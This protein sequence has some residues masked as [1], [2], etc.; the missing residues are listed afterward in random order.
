VMICK[1]AAASGQSGVAPRGTAVTALHVALHV[2]WTA[3][4]V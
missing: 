3:F 1:F 2:G 4:L